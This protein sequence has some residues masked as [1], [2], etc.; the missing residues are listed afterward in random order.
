[1]KKVLSL[2][3]LTI[4][5][6][7]LLSGCALLDKILPEEDQVDAETVLNDEYYKLAVEYGDVAKCEMITDGSMTS[8]CLDVVE[9][10]LLTDQARAEMDASLCDAIALP[11]YA[12]N[13]KEEVEALIAYEEKDAEV[14]AFYKTQ[15]ELVDSL[16]KDGNLNG[17]DQVKD[18]NYK[19]DCVAAILTDKAIDRGDD[20]YCDD[21]GDIE[22]EEICKAE[23]EGH[24]E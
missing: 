1:M 4:A 22:F 17:C 20:S 13:C 5:L 12:D 11:K 16:I 10:M 7:T 23:V 18:E 24:Q 14:S 8:E 9:A 15:A 2:S 6:V 19:L 21:I 3:V